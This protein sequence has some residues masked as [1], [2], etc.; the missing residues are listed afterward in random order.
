MIK[1]TNALEFVPEFRKFITAS[2]TGR[3]AM[4]SGKKL[5]KG[6]LVQYEC[7]YLLL[8][9][10]E[11]YKGEAIR[12]AL[13]YKNNLRLL[14][15]EKNYWQ[16]FIRQFADFM[17]K[18]KN[19]QDNYIGTVYKIIKTFFRYLQ[20]E[21]TL[22]VGDF[23]KKFR[24]PPVQPNPV[25]L[26]PQQLNFLITDAYFESTL[27]KSLK[28]VKDIFV[29]GCTVALRFQDLMNLK[30]KNIQYTP[31]GVF[32]TMHTQKTSTTIKIPLPDYAVAIVKRYRT[33]AG[34][35]ILPRLSGT[36]LNIYIKL[37]M[38]KAGWHYSLPKIGQCKGEPVEIKRKNGES[39]RY[40]DHITAH[41]MRRTA[42]TTLLLLGVDENSVRRISG[43]A[44]GS[45]EFYRYVVI[46]QDYL[47]AQVK[48]AHLRLLNE[49]M[50][51]TKNVA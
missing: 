49:S 13:L 34:S 38:Y 20:T 28:K 15:K 4:A 3:R 6:T 29:F 41:T 45:K 30:K 46:V 32:V 17:Y 26:T 33:K 36:N 31:E 44:P 16:K 23:Y 9:D 7:V 22:P 40:C 24:V 43:H 21:K 14:T 42:I 35:Y 51:L 12:I 1:K 48:Q 50:T 2:K 8:H 5:R 18:E 11:Q 19:C 47:N 37:L 10:F 39:W 27:S 25:I